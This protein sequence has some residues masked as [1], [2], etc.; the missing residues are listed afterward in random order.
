MEN[1][2]KFNGNEEEFKSLNEKLFESECDLKISLYYDNSQ[3]SKKYLG[4]LI[5]NKY[6]GRGIL[7][8]EDGKIKYNGYFK[9]GKYHGYGRLYMKGVLKY[10]GFFLEDYYSGKG[11]LYR[12]NKIEYN[13]YFKR[14]DYEGIGIESVYKGKRKLEFYNGKPKNNSYGV[15]YNDKD[16]IVYEGILID[17]KPEKAR[18]IAIYY[19]N[20]CIKYYGDFLNYKYN[21]NGILFY[22][23]KSLYYFKGIFKDDNYITGILYDKNKSILYKGDF[24]NN[25]PKEGKNILIYKVNGKLKY[26]GDI[27]DGK[28]HGIGLL[29]DE[30]DYEYEGILIMGYMKEKENYMNIFFVSVF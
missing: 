5:E 15:L 19:D 9:K 23:E 28:Y 8:D 21:G 27:L 7:Y 16:N 11:I 18:N 6:E 29:K 12:G 17:Q 10:E 26:K 4:N 2:K 20:G 1:I 30:N 24:V 22:D 3:K 13:G 25:L 14:G